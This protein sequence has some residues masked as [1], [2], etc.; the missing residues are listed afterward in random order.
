[1]CSTKLPVIGFAAFSGTGKTTLVSNII[2]LL[3]NRSLKIGIL[4][5]AH[6]N[7][8]IDQPGKDSHEFRKAG[9]QQV[10]IASKHRIAWVKE[11][12][13][14][15][16]PELM[17]TLQFFASQKLDLVIVEGFKKAPFTKIEVHRSKIKRPLLAKKDPHVIAIATDSPDKVD[18]D[19]TILNLEDYEGIAEFIM[20]RMENNTLT[21][22]GEN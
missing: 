8:V 12:E 14:Q 4:K 11:K 2:P 22:V 18:L 1:M 6:H 17:E 5:H 21:H 10:L 16:E 19:R 13:K 20:R 15:E 3:R 7:F 9:A